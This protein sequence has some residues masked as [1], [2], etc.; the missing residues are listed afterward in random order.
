MFALNLAIF[1]LF[2]ITAMYLFNAFLSHR[3]KKI[4]YVYASLYITT[5]A[6]LGVFGEVLIDSL[7]VLLT[8]RP[9]WEYHL[10]PIHS[11]Y[12]SYYSLAIW[13]MYGF[14]LYVFH[15]LL[16]GRRSKLSKKYLFIV[17]G[18]EAILLEVAINIMYLAFFG[19]YIFYYLPND[20]WHLTSIQAIPFYFVLG[21]VISRCIKRFRVDTRFF[22]IMNICLL[23]VMVFFAD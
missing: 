4:D 23:G 20:L 18:T 12:T 14:Y 3:F 16:K 6:L 11:S 2:C 21:T 17:V 19:D 15:D 22:I 9:L 1:T 13:G 7:F 10:L 8:K 5:V